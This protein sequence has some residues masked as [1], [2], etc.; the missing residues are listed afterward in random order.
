MNKLDHMLGFAFQNGE[1]C[2]LLDDNFNSNQNNSKLVNDENSF[3]LS[4]KATPLTTFSSNDKVV[5]NF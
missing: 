1:E 4:S 5:Y 3:L 2:D